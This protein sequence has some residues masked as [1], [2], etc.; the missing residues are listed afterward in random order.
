MTSTWVGKKEDGYAATR[1]LR[2]VKMDNRE[3]VSRMR[4]TK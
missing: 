3:D 1:L 2:L 4:Q